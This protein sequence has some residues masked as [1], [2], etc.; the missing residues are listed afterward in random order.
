VAALITLSNVYDLIPEPTV[1]IEGTVTCANSAE[2]VC[3]YINSD[4]GQDGNAERIPTSRLHVARY[5][6]RLAKGTAFKIGVGCGGSP[7][8]WKDSISSTS[9][10]AGD[11]D[12][13]C[14]DGRENAHP[15]V[16][17]SVDG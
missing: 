1:T 10:P 13:V 14:Y 6:H 2:V 15:K 17:V 4:R 16:C 9:V 7:G 3:I 8:R 5:R 11:H 12:F